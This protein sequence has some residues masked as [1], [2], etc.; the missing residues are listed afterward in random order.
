MR[1]EELIE[2][3]LLELYL[4]GK[5]N[6]EETVL[7]EKNLIEKEVQL[8][9]NRIER[10][11]LE[12]ANRQEPKPSE[13]VK[14]RLDKTLDFQRQ[15]RVIRLN[16]SKQQN[17]VA[18][19]GVAL[20]VSL[21]VNMLQYTS[22]K[23]TKLQLAEAKNINEVLSLEVGLAKDDNEHLSSIVSFF[24]HGKIEGIP[25]K[26]TT[27]G[28]VWGRIYWDKETGKTSIIPNEL[29]KINADQSYQLWAVINGKPVDLG[30]I[31]GENI[32]TEHFTMLKQ[33]VKPEAFCITIEPLGGKE[34]P[35]LEKLVAQADF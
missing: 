15:N 29:P 25:I 23:N 21:S 5:T 11:L 4:L 18:A 19:A 28:H 16:V 31:P 7:V 17:W 13:A 34:K 30:V 26:C 35:T 3:G 8:E 14:L 6:T 20:I 32:G 9:L 10:A 1:K 33:A 27:T 12:E 2:S 24:E 22:H